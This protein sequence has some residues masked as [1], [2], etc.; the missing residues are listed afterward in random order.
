MDRVDLLLLGQLDDRLDVQ[1]AADRLAGLADLVGLVGL[2]AM[3]RE[4][5]FVRVDRHGPDAQLVGRAEDPD[6]DLAAVGGH[7]L[8]ECGIESSG[9][10]ESRGRARS[11]D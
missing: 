1:I 2:E 10:K 7:Q 5:V 6:R 11:A 4:P 3:R 8:A 9:V